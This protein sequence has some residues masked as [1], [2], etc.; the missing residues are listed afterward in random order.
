MN[1]GSLK[2]KRILL[3]ELEP[4]N[5]NEAYIMKKIFYIPVLIISLF[6]AC[7]N[8]V[9]SPDVNVGEGVQINI[10]PPSVTTVDNQH[11][12]AGWPDNGMPKERMPGGSTIRLYIYDAEAT[13]GVINPVS[14]KRVR[15][16][17]EG[18]TF[19]VRSQEEIDASS[20][21]RA[22]VPCHVDPLTGEA[23]EDITDTDLHLPGSLYDFFAISPAIKL[24]D[25]SVNSYQVPG[26]QLRHGGIM[27]QGATEPVTLYTSKPLM[28]VQ[29]GSNDPHVTGGTPGVYNLE[30]EPF[31]LLTSRVRFIIIPGTDVFNMEIEDRGV[32]MDGLTFN[33]FNYNFLIGDAMLRETI[34]DDDDAVFGT[35]SI[36]SARK[37][38]GEAKGYE[39]GIYEKDDTWELIT[40]VIPNPASGRTYATTVGLTFNLLINDGNYKSYD[41][42]L[43]DQR[44]LRGSEYTYEVTVNA[45]GIFVRGWR[46]VGWTATIPN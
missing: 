18:V 46:N 3:L 38:T 34:L 35:V 28:G 10:L 1:P 11:T 27:P 19:R 9:A 26:W 20:D 43:V 14:D 36:T 31:T 22:V 4:I 23:L 2:I 8:E 42:Y 32:V 13:S 37:I 12:R 7:E 41:S 40:E 6:T 5:S 25:W 30:L 33:A 44:F 24:R 29:V 16:M 17:E 39:P 45:G 15:G 21:K